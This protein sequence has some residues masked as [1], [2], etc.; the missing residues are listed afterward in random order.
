MAR[1]Y[2]GLFFG[3]SAILWLTRGAPASAARTAILA[4]GAVV[5]AIMTIVSAVG[6]LTGV[7]GTAVWGVVVV[8]ALLATGFTYYL[9]SERR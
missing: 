8:E 5:T 3:Y 4:G 7:V 9:V 1:R 2:G 6:V